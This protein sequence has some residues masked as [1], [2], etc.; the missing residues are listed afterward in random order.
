[1]RGDRRGRRGGDQL[2]EYNNRKNIN[3]YIRYFFCKVNKLDWMAS[4]ESTATNVSTTTTKV[5]IAVSQ[6]K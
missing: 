1:M 2:L 3:L 4:I 6:N 5:H